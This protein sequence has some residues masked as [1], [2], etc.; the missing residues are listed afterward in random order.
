VLASE[1]GTV[2]VVSTGLGEGPLP[3]IVGGPPAEVLSVEP[4]VG[5]P[6]RV[7]VKLRLPAEAAAEEWPAARLTLKT[8][9]FMTQ[10]GVLA[11]TR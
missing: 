4:I 9:E 1:P 7:A 10:Q 8:G 6:G 3:A 5:A 11:R 2:T